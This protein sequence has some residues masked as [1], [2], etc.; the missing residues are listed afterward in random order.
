[1]STQKQGNSGLGLEAQKTAVKNFLK[2]DDIL[3]S[4]YTET[5]SAK[6]DERPK[7]LYAIEECSSSG[8]TLL[9]AKLDRLSRNVKFIYTLKESNID[10]TCCD[11]PDASPLT[12]GIMAVLAEEEREQISKR[13]Q[14]A[15]AELIRK[16]VKLGSPQNLTKEARK[17]GTDAIIKKALKN[18]NNKKA[19]SLIVLLRKEKLSY[20]KIADKLNEDGFKTSTGKEFASSQVYVLYNRYITNQVN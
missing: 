3:L 5:E 13:T 9:I 1:M 17:K 4:E 20:Q 7:L 10:F 19:T 2:L 11:M 14:L 15:L 8:A 16:G 18:P 6:L 12:I